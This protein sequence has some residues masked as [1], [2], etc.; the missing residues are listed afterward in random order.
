MVFQFQTGIGADALLGWFLRGANSPSE[1]RE[2]R[3]PKGEASRGICYWQV[4]GIE[5]D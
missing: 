5:L 4:E 2:L 3:P 1:P